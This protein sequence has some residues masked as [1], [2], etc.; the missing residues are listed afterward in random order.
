MAD[1]HAEPMPARQP[2]LRARRT[3]LCRVLA[4]LTAGLLLVASPAAAASKSDP[5]QQRK[6]VQKKR[7]QVAAQ[8]DV[9]KA[10]DKEVE[11][12]LDALNADV[13]RQEAQLADARQA[14]DVADRQL[15]D[16]RAAEE[17]TARRLGELHETMRRAAVDAYV[18]GPVADSMAVFEASSIADAARM[19]TLSQ[20]VSGKRADVADELSAAKEDLG[21]QREAAERAQAQ[22]AARRTQV[23]ARLGKLTAARGQQQRVSNAVED[24]L[25]S[26]LAEADSLA[27][28]DKQ[29]AADIARRQEEIAN[30]LRST[31]GGQRASRGAPRR[32][33]S[34][35]L[36][37]VRGIT[38]NSQIADQLERLLAAAEADGY[39]F[40]G[41]GYRS[42]DDQV[43][44]RR[45]HC[46]TSDYDIYEKPASQCSPPTARP[47]ASMHEQGLAI[48]FT[49]AGSLITSRSSPA[50][51]WLARN[52]GGFGLYNLPSEP[53]HW[54][55]N[56]N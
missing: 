16:A 15:A 44:A 30:R 49:S 24:R 29:L 17:A 35:S 48:D 27:A 10:S 41:G 21:V 18:R 3:R 47:G 31:G 8:I 38:V 51:Q 6:E 42:S 43:A 50:Y 26:A 9:L 4:G 14:A 36:T 7:A 2:T 54:S 5:T 52:A 1:R 19:S 11:D 56:G 28:V 23:E 45:A 53:W 40:G 37:T 22:A 34:I 33:G 25:D 13:R 12:A 46:G 55:T 20:F 39:T 32:A